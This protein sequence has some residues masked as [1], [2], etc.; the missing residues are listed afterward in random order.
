MSSFGQTWCVH[1]LLVFPIGFNSLLAQAL[2]TLPCAASEEVMGVRCWRCS[3]ATLPSL[4]V[5]VVSVQFLLC[6]MVFLSTTAK[7]GK[8][9][10]R[11]INL[12]DYLEHV[13]YSSSMAPW[14]LSTALM[15]IHGTVLLRV[16][17]H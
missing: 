17:P 7:M 8:V 1:G 3:S 9:P 6:S 16:I 15:V 14:S 10:N 2:V 5:F 13:D 4:Q 12:F 11:L